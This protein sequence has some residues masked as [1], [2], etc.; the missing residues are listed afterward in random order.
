MPQQKDLKRIVRSRM[1][2]T[3]ESYTAARVHIIS[4]KKSIAPDLE[5]GPDYAA[6]A[7]MTDATVERA[8][9]R[10]LSKW[11]ETLDAWGAAEKPHRDIA[12]HV[13]S[14]G[15]SGWWSQSVAVGY[16]RIRGLR[17]IG[18]RR[19]GSWEASK[20]KTFHVPLAAL[21][22]ACSDARARRRWLTG[23]E[24]IVRSSAVEKTMRLAFDDGTVAQ[25]Y[26]TWKTK[27]KSLLTVQHTKIPS[28][29]QTDRMKL[30][31]S[32]RLDALARMLARKKR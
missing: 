10:P 1:Q 25:F 22:A 21:Y 4:K 30:F 18:Q 11:V 5:P 20:S 3:G 6:L 15:V 24:S 19:N 32:E 12:A 8:T 14:L 2:K 27:E 26:F 13:N 7:G 28:K 16:E 17:A 31:W 29:E 9:G 23:P